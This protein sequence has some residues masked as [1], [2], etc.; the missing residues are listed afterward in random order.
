M[1]LVICDVGNNN[2]I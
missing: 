1:N 2:L